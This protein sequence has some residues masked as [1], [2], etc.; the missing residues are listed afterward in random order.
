MKTPPLLEPAMPRLALPVIDPDRCTGCGRCVAACPERVL[1]LEAE[2]ANGMGR[3]RAVLHDEPGC[4][5]CAKCSPVCPFDALQMVRV[6]G[7]SG[8]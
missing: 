1:W 4:T 6:K 5:G 2:Q 8:A 7:W 3:K